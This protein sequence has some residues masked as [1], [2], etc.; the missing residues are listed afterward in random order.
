M[1]PQ[2]SK[3]IP[4]AKPEF[5]R[6]ETRNGPQVA[7]LRGLLRAQHL[8]TVCEEA[9]CPNLGKCFK[10][11]TSTFLILGKACTRSCQFCAVEKGVPLPVDPEEPGHLA[12]TSKGLGLKHVVITSVTRDDL[13]DGG[14]EQ[15]YESVRAVKSLLPEASVEVLTPDFQGDLGAVSRVLAS[16]PSVYNHNLE[17]V[18]RLYGEVRPE[19]DYKRSLSLLE[20]VRKSGAPATVKS[21]IMAG[22]GES[23]EEIAGLMKDLVSAGCQVLTIGQYLA[24]SRKHWPVRKYYDPLEYEEL[25]KTGLELGLE[26]VFAGP[27]VRSSFN[28]GEVYAQLNGHRQL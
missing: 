6:S 22:M 1:D 9:H 20:F 10:S 14:A 26:L 5:L 25:Q 3:N 18:P 11:G 7:R 13:A 4:G 24:P 21:G 16:G 19:A 8:H 12:E 23:K 2:C 17:T 15:F 28:A 27:L